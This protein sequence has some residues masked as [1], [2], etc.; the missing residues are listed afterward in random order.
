MK[1]YIKW[2]N[3]YIKNKINYNKIFNI[4]NK[5]GF[6]CKLNY[7]PNNYI[8]IK[9]IKIIKINYLI[10]FLII[11]LKKKI[12]KIKILNIKNINIFSYKYILININIYKILNYKRKIFYI[13]LL[14]K[15]KNYKLILIQNIINNNNIINNK[16][17][18]INI[19]YNRI[20][21]NSIYYISKLICKLTNNIF[22]NKSIK[23]KINYKNNINYDL[24]ITKKTKKNIYN[25]KYIILKQN[26]TKKKKYNIPIY[27]KNYLIKNGFIYQNNLSD[28]IKYSAIEYGLNLIYLDYKKIKNKKIYIEIKKNKNI[29]NLFIKTSKHIIVKNYDIYNKIYKPNFNTKY[30]ILISILFNKNFIIKN[31]NKNFNNWLLLNNNINKKTQDLHLKKVCFLI[32]NIN[33][34]K[35]IHFKTKQIN[36]N[37][38]SKILIH[39]SKIN[40]KIGIKIKKNKIINIIKNLDCK[41]IKKYKFLLIMQHNYRYDLNIYEDYIEEILK[42][43]DFNNIKTKNFYSY[44]NIISTNN[45]YNYYINN[46]KIFLSNIGY[47]EI[48]NF[49]FS[50]KKKERIYNNK[51]YIKIKNP[52]SYNKS[53]LRTTL[54]PNLLKTL[55]YNIKRQIYNIKL[56]EIGTCYKYK[57][58][59]IKLN[60][61]LCLILYGYKYQKTWNI[62]KNILFDFYDL[63]N[64]LELIFKKQYK[65]KFLNLKKSKHNF[66]DKHQNANIYYKKNNIGYI[67]KLNTNIQKKLSNKFP[68]Y[69]LEIKIDKILIPNKI[70]INKICK[71]TFSIRDITLIINQN[72]NI[73][74]IIKICKTIKL[75]KKIKIINLFSNNYLNKINK[76][77]ITIRIKIQNKKRTLIESEINQIIY[78]CKK[79]LKYKLNALI[80]DDI[81]KLNNK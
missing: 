29:N 81:K 67:G 46:I 15:K 42:K 49:H 71:Y 23:Y 28:I 47:T 10:Y 60:T 14:K 43:I 73:N 20:E 19:P 68:I 40:K 4:L 9:P 78:N 48:I 76:K 59:N 26:Y 75:I 25:Y 74:K 27:I 56:F 16:Y 36:N 35:I 77:N 5:N 12:L 52:I 33:K 65:I 24:Y 61:K 58:N 22:I 41:I 63:K 39:Y 70:K 62:K 21:C 18:D 64:D 2:I 51:K 30:L 6:E 55:N 45:N 53:I 11:K 66:L 72:I 3:K 7:I 17:I 50:C 79:L 13:N 57:N 80:D 38:K 69:I 44:T 37:I 34:S 54:L 1:F 32:K 8:K 31:F